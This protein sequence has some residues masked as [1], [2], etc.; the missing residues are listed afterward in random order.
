MHLLDSKQKPPGTLPSHRE[1]SAV[2]SFHVTH[3]FA[4]LHPERHTQ[5]ALLDKGP[6]CKHWTPV[7]SAPAPGESGEPKGPCPQW[8]LC[9]CL[10]QV[11]HRY[12]STFGQDGGSGSRAVPGLRGR[13]E[14]R[15]SCCTRSISSLY[16]FSVGIS[17]KSFKQ[18][19]SINSK[20]K[21]QI[22]SCHELIKNGVYRDSA[23]CDLGQ[24]SSPL[25]LHFIIYKM[26]ELD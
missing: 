24:F 15:E 9:A 16:A 19:M 18:W 25:G 2:A 3:P 20:V 21:K 12:Q 10:E 26:R 8:I 4:T 17:G 23:V 14:R 13:E 5:V 7:N 22:Y 1:R 11:P 6:V